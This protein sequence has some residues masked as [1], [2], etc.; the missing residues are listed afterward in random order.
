MLSSIRMMICRRVARASSDGAPGRLL[1]HVTAA[2]DPAVRLAEDARRRG[3]VDNQALVG[4]VGMQILQ[5]PH[6]EVSG[7]VHALGA[8]AGAPATSM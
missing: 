5:S 3:R 1:A 7:E 2:A 6:Q 4:I 8:H